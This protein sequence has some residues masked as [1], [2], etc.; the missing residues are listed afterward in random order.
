METLYDLL[1]ALPRDDAEELR[2][3]FR[4]AVKGVHPDLHPGDPEAG[5]KFRQIV[6]ANQILADS[7]QRAAYDHL[8]DLAD[9]EQRQLSKRAVAHTVYQVASGAIAFC[10]ASAAIAGGYL[11]LSQMPDEWSEPIGLV[12]AIARQS[13]DS[14]ATALRQSALAATIAVRE[15]TEAVTVAMRQSTETVT[16]AVQQTTETV[17][18]AVIPELPATVQEPPVALP[19]PPL[20]IARAEK[21]ESIELP[22]DPIVPVAVTLQP[23]IGDPPAAN[24]GPPLDLT[25]TPVGARTYREHGIIAYRNGDLNGAIADFDHAIQL[26]PKFAAAYIDRGIVFYRMQKYDRA[27]ADLARAKRIEKTSRTK[28]AQQM[29]DKKLRSSR[30]LVETTSPAPPRRTANLDSSRQEPFPYVRP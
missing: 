18:A 3:A 30:G 12:A 5:L 23:S 16:T 29:T 19:E 22:P 20:Q 27:F 14:A 25:P 24:I 17:T 15:S 9:Q 7:E 10:V 28:P 4:R 21:L 6:R 1:G 8:L 13:T 11:A 26:D 2:V